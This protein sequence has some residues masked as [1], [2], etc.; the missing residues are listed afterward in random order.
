MSGVACCNFDDFVNAMADETRQ[1]ILALLQARELS[2]GDLTQHFPVTQPTISHHLAVLR[3]ANLVIARH[4][5]RQTFYRSN[6]AC[7]VECCQE[8][9]HRFDSHWQESPGRMASRDEGSQ[10]RG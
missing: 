5:G 4:D 8:I 3:H 6:P 2:V 7:V 1:R 10:H 9:L